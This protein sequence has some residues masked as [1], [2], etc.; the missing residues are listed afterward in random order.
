MKSRFLS[1]IIWAIL[2]F[3]AV[4]SNGQ[5]GNLKSP[6]NVKANYAEPKLRPW[7]LRGNSGT[8]TSKHFIGTRDA[9]PLVFKVNNQRS[10]YLDWDTIG[11]LN[12]SFGYQSLSVLSGPEAAH[13]SAF[14]YRALYSNTTGFGNTAQG[15]GALF[16]NTTG[17]INTA[18]GTEALFTNTTGEFNTAIGYNT[19]YG[20]QTG[21]FNTATGDYALAGN[22]TGQAN[23]ANGAAFTLSS[24]TEGSDNIATGVFGLGSNSTG[25]ANV[26]YGSYSL[27]SNVTGSNNTALGF[28]TDVIADNLN[29]A[30]AIGNGALVDA[31]NKVRIGNA[32]VTSIGGEVGWTSFS[33]ERIKDKIKE[34]VPG[35]EFIKA[36]RPVTYHFS[37]EKENALF[38]V[39]DFSAQDIA[40]PQ[41]KGTKM[42]GIKNAEMEALRNLTQ[43][44]AK[45][46]SNKTGH[47]IEKIQFTGFLAQ[48]V[49]KA[50]K[51]I[52]YDFSGI[53]KSGKVMGLRYSDFVV[54]LV[55]AVQ[56]LSKM[57]EEKD[58]KIDGLQKQIDELKAKISSSSSIAKTSI[59]L[60]DVL[61]EQNTPNPFA[62]SSSIR[63]NIPSTAKNAL[64]LITDNLGKTV[65]QIPLNAGAGFV[66]IDAAM[67]SSGSYNYSLFI[68]GKMIETKKM[69]KAN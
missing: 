56:E 27:V 4:N 21:W 14:G 57:N 65:K 61:L 48:D 5:N 7:L 51:S 60:T 10:G 13:L 25:N 63:Y 38:G 33:D 46:L 68:D 41:I 66:N 17:N 45:T 6:A 9:Q 37:I 2:S 19:L 3:C 8:D 53:D 44:R 69:I 47:D 15:T 30:T 55:K 64:L 16:F 40:F 34:N 49:D 1:A 58:A 50:A 67:L 26:A 36:L 59:T 24:N 54:P 39:K 43:Q 42:P 32:D 35:L 23:I 28:G 52:G 31:S 62:N 29:N 18:I 11:S 20:N 12:T 22:T